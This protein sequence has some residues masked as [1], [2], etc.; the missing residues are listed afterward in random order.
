[1]RGHGRELLAEGVQDPAEL[2]VHRRGVGLVVNRVQ[3]GPDPA[4]ADFGVADIRFAA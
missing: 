2:S 3:Q 4:H 1:M